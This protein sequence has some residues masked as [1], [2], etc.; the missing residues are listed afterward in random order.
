MEGRT[1]GQMD[2]NGPSVEFLELTVEILGRILIAFLLTV[3]ISTVHGWDTIKSLPQRDRLLL[4]VLLNSRVTVVMVG[5]EVPPLTVE[6]HMKTMMKE[7]S[8]PPMPTIQV[9]LRKRMTPKM[10]WMQGR[11]TPIRVPSCGAWAGTHTCRN[12]SIKQKL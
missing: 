7:P 8:T 4:L 6:Q 1:V 12:T 10:F 11:Y 5:D 3:I 9:I 2:E